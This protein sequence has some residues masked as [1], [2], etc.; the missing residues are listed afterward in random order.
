M[1]SHHY[2]FWCICHFKLFI[3]CNYLIHFEFTNIF[4]RIGGKNWV[5]GC[6]TTFYAQWTLIKTYFSQ[7]KCA[8]TLQNITQCVCFFRNSIFYIPRVQESCCDRG[9]ESHWEHGYFSV[10]S[11]AC[12]QVEVSATDWSL[13]QRSSTDCGATLRV[14]KKPRTR[15]GYRPARGLQ[16]TNPQCVVRPV[17]KER[18]QEYYFG[19]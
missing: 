19:R 3:I 4:Y 10:V 8:W 13:V 14:I 2:I 7:G 9:F 17:E 6:V 11:L 18:V 1:D 12:L 15:G 16:N 5:T